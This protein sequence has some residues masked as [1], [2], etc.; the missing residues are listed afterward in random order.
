MT[1]EPRS[2]LY[3]IMAS[4]GKAGMVEKGSSPKTYRLGTKLLLLGNVV[5]TRLSERQAAMKPMKD[6]Q[7]QTQQTIS[8]FVKRDTVAV[9]VERLD[10][11][12]VSS[13]FVEVG[14]QLPLYAGEARPLLAY[15]DERFISQY[16][17]GRRIVA[18]TSKAPGSVPEVRQ[19][20]EA[21]R[22]LGYTMSDEETVLGMATLSA[23]VLNFRGEVCASLA[24]SGPKPAIM[25]DKLNTNVQLLLQAAAETSR[26]MGYLPGESE[27]IG[28]VVPMRASSGR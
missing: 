22:A 18:L 14:G 17:S 4:L 6:L 2:S 27:G 9:C 8:L 12:M 23:P 10:G 26:A 28:V 25:A 1:G 16:F 24:V 11:Q 20:L 13:T 19:R 21:T 15:E 3:R 7:A 5:A